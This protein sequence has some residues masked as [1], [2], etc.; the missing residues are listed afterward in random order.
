[1]KKGT[2]VI[3]RWLQPTRIIEDDY[4]FPFIHTYGKKEREKKLVHLHVDSLL[5][6]I[7]GG[8]KLDFTAS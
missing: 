5:L 3:H 4:F 7:K 2:V 1:M 6:H 8:G